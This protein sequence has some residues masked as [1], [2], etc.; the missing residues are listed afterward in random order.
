MVT[1]QQVRRLRRFDRQGLT[2][3]QAADKV[4]IDAKTARK[5]RQLGKLPSEV[6]RMEHNWRTRPDPFGDVWPHLEELLRV[7]PGLL[8]T[9]LFAELQRQHPGRFTANQLRTLQRRLKR[10][11]AL[12]APAKEV[13]F[14]QI[15]EPGRL[16]ASDFTHCSSLG[17]T[18]AGVP[19]PHLIYHFVLTYSNWETGTICFAESLESLSEGFQD[20]VWELGGVA[21]V[22]R[23]DRLTAAIPPGEEGQAFTQRYQALL[24][25]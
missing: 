9:T 2:K 14:A 6:P 1:D 22:H 13:F 23:T 5:Y 21:Q 17:V 19:F 25:H 24:G 20:A 8:A 12:H 7:N 16:C 11:R 3:A 4:G 18:I 10:W 15:H